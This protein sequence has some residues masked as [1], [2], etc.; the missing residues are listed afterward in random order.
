M[1]ID[2]PTLTTQTVLVL[3]SPAMCDADEML[4]NPARCD[5]GA[6]ETAEECGEA[7]L[8]AS[9]CNGF[10]LYGK[11]WRSD[12]DQMV[13]ECRCCS[14]DEPV[15]GG[16]VYGGSM[17]GYKIETVGASVVAASA[18]AAGSTTTSTTGIR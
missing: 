10:F 13:Y 14:E 3:E 11:P 12:P 9:T 2:A 1:G 8:K 17:T 7:T 6:F 5:F 4:E 18:V 16:S 15:Y